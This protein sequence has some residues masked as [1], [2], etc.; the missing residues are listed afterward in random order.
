MAFVGLVR[1]CVHAVLDAV[2][3][4][5]ALPDREYIERILARLRVH[6]KVELAIRL[7]GVLIAGVANAV[8]VRIFLVWIGDERTVVREVV[9]AVAVLVLVLAG[10]S[11]VVGVTLAVDA[12]E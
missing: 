9:G 4:R 8:S 5:V 7:R 1:S 6:S 3:V 10:V 11:I 2:V 12:L